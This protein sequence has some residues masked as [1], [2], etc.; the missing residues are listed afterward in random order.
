MA[1][2]VGMEIEEEAKKRTQKP[3]IPEIPE[4]SRLLLVQDLPDLFLPVLDLFMLIEC[5]IAKPYFWTSGV[6]RNS[7]EP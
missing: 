2:L 5:V 1:E 7:Q 3:R 6:Y 4:V